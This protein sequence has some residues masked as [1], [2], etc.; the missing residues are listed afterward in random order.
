M[1]IEPADAA[2]VPR[3]LEI[4]RAAFA[5]QA[6]SAYSPEE[7]ATLLDDVDLAELRSMIMEDQ[8][9][10][11]LVDQRI[12]GLA[13]WRGDRLRHVYV[14]PAHTGHHIGTQLVGRAEADFRARTGH[15]VIKAGVALHAEGF[16]RKIGYEVV[17]RAKA[18]D[19]SGYL[20]MTRHLAG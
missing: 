11:A 10:V 9:F 4:R 5:E 17:G 2:D 14:D 20:E 19:G 1:L 12:V 18:W 7:V 15:A 16:Y 13:G 8:L 3:I 6:P